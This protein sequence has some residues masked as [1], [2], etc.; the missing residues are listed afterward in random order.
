ME[1]RVVHVED[2]LGGDV[3]TEH[4]DAPPDAKKHEREVEQ[5]LT[6]PG[7]LRRPHRPPWHPQ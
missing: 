6:S 4:A 5:N 3:V 7:H 1:P 2:F